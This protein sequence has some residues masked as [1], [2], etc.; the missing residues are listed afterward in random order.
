MKKK[1]SKILTNPPEET[2]IWRYLDISKFIFMLSKKALIFS[3]ADKL[4][5]PFEGSYS[6][7]SIIKMR[8]NCHEN[9]TEEDSKSFFEL[10]KKFKAYTFVNCWHMNEFESAA[11]WKLYLKSN[12]GVAIQSTYKNLIKT[13]DQKRVKVDIAVGQVEYIDYDKDFMI[14]GNPLF[15]FYYKRRSFEHEHELRAAFTRIPT[16]RGISINLAKMRKN[17][18][19][20]TIDHSIN[21]NNTV[22]IIPINLNTLI[23]KIYVPPTAEDWFKEII[24]SLLKKFRAT[25][26]VERSELENDPVF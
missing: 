13:L 23:E 3:R 22:E 1:K 24:E 12:E 2:K 14:D 6:K 26:N 18:Y 21:L 5:D 19:N 8:E 11:M 25:V 16:E 7:P 4:D 9:L 15:A 17:Y 20:V 10:N